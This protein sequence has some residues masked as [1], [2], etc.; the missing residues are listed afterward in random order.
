M[1]G[2]GRTRFILALASSLIMTASAYALD[3][4]NP[5]TT[6]DMS[7]CAAIAY[8]KADEELNDVY[9][10]LRSMLDEPGKLLLRDTQ[11]AWI[12]YRDAECARVADTFRGGSMA[13][14]AH[15]SCLSEMTSRRSTELRTDPATGEPLF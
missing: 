6:V 12:P 13:G 9:Q 11:R 10:Q 2:H 3:C 7:E 15:L 5:V 14:L 4:Q 1:T 8:Q